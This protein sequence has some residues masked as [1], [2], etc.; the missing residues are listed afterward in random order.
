[1][2]FAW[3]IC[4]PLLSIQIF[5]SHPYEILTALLIKTLGKMKRIDAIIRR[6]SLD[7]V[8]ERLLNAGVEGLTVAEVVGYGRQKGH[9]ETYRGAEYQVN[10]HPKLLLTILAR[11]DQVEDA[12]NAVIEGA[13]TGRIG[14]GKVFVSSIEE[15]VRIRTG[16][17]DKAAV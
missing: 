5:N 10:F 6:E 8:R 12:L 9:T 15:V 3:Y 16:E 7:T 1:M 14:D 17:I 4:F 11:E 2:N 13:R